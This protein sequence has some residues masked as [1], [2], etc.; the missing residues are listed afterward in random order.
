[1]VQNKEIEFKYPAKN[2]SLQTFNDFCKNMHDHV[3]YRDNLGT[4]KF[5]THPEKP[6]TFF[7]LRQDSGTLQLTF[8]RKIAQDNSMRIEYNLN[9]DNDQG[10]AHCLIEEM[11]YKY[12]TILHKVNHVHIFPWYV[13]SYYIC[14]NSDM[15]EYDRFIEIEMREDCK[16]TSE[17]EVFNELR[18]VEKM[19]KPLGI[20]PDK[21]IKESLYEMFRSKV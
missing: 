2:I 10:S 19:F 20:S 21:R 8:K 13:L 9:V 14:Y 6:D 12:D 16:W 1:M 5:F 4:D 11:G 15:V 18:I 17:Q 7:R 3:G